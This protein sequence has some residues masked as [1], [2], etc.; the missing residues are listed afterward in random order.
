MLLVEIVKQ[1]AVG[2]E[3]RYHGVLIVVDAH[4]HV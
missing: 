3:L 2:Q 4:A 1:A